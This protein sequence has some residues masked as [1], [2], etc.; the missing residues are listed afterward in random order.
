MFAAFLGIA[1]A[2]SQLGGSLLER[3]RGNEP[4]WFYGQIVHATGQPL[5]GASLTFRIRYSGTR[6][7]ILRVARRHL[8]VELPSIPD[9]SL[10]SA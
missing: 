10:L 8:Q 2:A 6:L 9:D 1:I 3:I 5:E 7:R 4:I